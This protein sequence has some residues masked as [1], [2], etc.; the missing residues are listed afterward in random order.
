M[1]IMQI[2]L[3][4]LLS[5][6][7]VGQDTASTIIPAN[8][9]LGVDQAY[10]KVRTL[11]TNTLKR[12]GYKKVIRKAKAVIKKYPSSDDRFKLINII[13]KCQQGLLL[14]NNT[15]DNREDVFATARELAKAPP[16]YSKIKLQADLLLLQ[17]EL[18]SAKMTA[19]V[20]VKAIR[21]L[22][23]GYLESP[24]EADCLM[25]LITLSKDL[26]NAELF[27]EFQ[28]ILT[29]RFANN[30]KVG[31]FLR[32]KLGVHKRDNRF[33]GDFKTINGK[34]I[35]FPIDP[36]GSNYIV[37][38]WSQKTPALKER[39]AEIQDYQ[40]KSKH[41]FEV[42][43]FNLDQLE[44]A[45]QSILEEKGMG[46]ATSM[47]LPGGTR[48]AAFQSYANR[49][50][51]YGFMSVNAIGYSLGTS[52]NSHANRDPIVNVF[53]MLNDKHYFALMQSISAGEF[54]ISEAGL[55][56]DK[57]K[58][59][60]PEGK[61]KEL[62]S[63]FPSTQRRYR[64]STPKI[65]KNYQ[66]A[67]ELSS[68][69]LKAHGNA[70]D[71]WKVR[72]CRII[73]LMAIWKADFSGK[74]LEMAVEEAKLALANNKIST[75][76]AVI[77][78][79]C[80]T[81]MAL[82]GQKADAVAL[83]KTFIKDCGGDQA[84]ATALAAATVLTVDGGQLTRDLYLTNRKTIFTRYPNEPKIMSVT[85]FLLTE[86]S[87]KYL[88]QANEKEYYFGSTSIYYRGISQ[89]HRGI[90]GMKR[91]VKADFTALSGKQINIPDKQEFNY[92]IC[93]FLD[94][95]KEGN[96]PPVF[97]EN[98]TAVASGV[99]YVVK[100][101]PAAP[102]KGKKWG[103]LTNEAQ[104]LEVLTGLA[105]MSK[106]AHL[107]NVKLV[108]FFLSEDKV[109]IKALMKKYKIDCEVVI[110][111]DGLENPVLTKFAV[112][113]QEKAINTVLISPDGKLLTNYSKLHHTPHTIHRNRDK[114]SR[115]VKQK[116]QRSGYNMPN[117]NPMKFD[118]T[119][120]FLRTKTS[121]Y[122]VKT[123][124][125]YYYM[126]QGINTKAMD[127]D[128]CCTAAY[129]IGRVCKKACCRQEINKGKICLTC[130]PSAKG[131]KL[132]KPIDK[133]WRIAA[134]YLRITYN[135][136]GKYGNQYVN[137]SKQ[138]A[139]QALFKVKDYKSVIEL[140]TEL[141]ANNRSP[142]YG[143]LTIPADAYEM[144]AKA[145][146]QLG[147]K[148]KAAA[149]LKF[150]KKSKVEK[151]NKKTAQQNRKSMRQKNKE[152][153]E[154]EFRKQQKLLKKYKEEKARQEKK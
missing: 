76:Q 102:P 64:T 47:L 37:F 81:K 66:K 112:F 92:N 73:A 114:R 100:N 55:Q 43:S 84:S 45:G 117:F 5:L 57:T 54:L 48:H 108:L 151:A 127:G 93:V 124:N 98:G 133:H 130:N 4:L 143:R 34:S 69:L 31:G 38:F 68:E 27:N 128:S 60:I 129:I 9:L 22:A 86:L 67:V 146:K 21:E 77:P 144:R 13:F 107:N 94:L 2:L 113:S 123:G 103:P 1:R 72:N 135:D 49:K 115:Y 70:A 3:T 26:E 63:Y 105:K 74:Y 8:K 82:R 149:D 153:K 85:A 28:V 83:L 32:E 89:K 71:L 95:P 35:S 50:S 79:F 141:I 139:F 154:A 30:P 80:L 23:Q 20:K 96:A 7:V 44:D 10:Y 61:L 40:S 19:E 75:E 125:L 152:K 65:I 36:I 134:N 25:Y 59:A 132:E 15:K 150:L 131:K 145:Y 41:S 126:A 97:S 119:E 109:A 99:N 39:L 106:E 18:A 110:L 58:T 52:Y 148:A 56:A 122:D 46:W 6:S 12:R 140:A 118:Q 90:M 136:P 137:R 116:F 33:R 53:A 138:R 51:L 62:L 121:E 42:Y 17:L 101:R 16:A 11:S 104:Q 142:K 88:F 120:A 24:A 147:E 29:T 91:N 111:K 87:C 14:I 78:R